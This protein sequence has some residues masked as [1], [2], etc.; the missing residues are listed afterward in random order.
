MSQPM[1]YSMP[2]R[3]TEQ[4]LNFDLSTLYLTEGIIA[5]FLDLNVLARISDVMSG[6]LKF[7]DSPLFP[8]T[9][10]LNQADRSKITIVPGFALGES[11][12]Q[13]KN[14]NYENYES[15]VS[16]VLPGFLDAP[17]CIRPTGKV[18]NNSRDNLLMLP[19]VLSLIIAS[20]FRVDK[21]KSME[22]R[23]CE[24]LKL[25]AELSPVVSLLDIEI[26][27]FIIFESSIGDGLSK[28]ELTACSLIKENFAIS[29]KSK[30]NGIEMLWNSAN[31][32]NYIRA[33][34]FMSMEKESV[35]PL[36][37]WIV[38]SDQK[39]HALLE[40]VKFPLMPIHTLNGSI[41]TDTRPREY[42]ENIYWREVDA[43]TRNLMKSREGMTLYKN[44]AIEFE[45]IFD[46]LRREIINQAKEMWGEQADPFSFGMTG[47]D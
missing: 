31:D 30:K 3:S 38:T 28:R 35:L 32:I 1:Y 2:V 10:I 39:L 5:L 18:H 12:F 34:V 26:A 19:S 37:P 24:Y 27:K 6:K 17:D 9:Q 25:Y 36:V 44:S 43:A 13:K 16:M 22:N 23:F 14:E 15:F 11:N 29:T 46:R 45:R 21:S 33:S 40:R 41:I 4:S 8:L 47:S 42:D 7:H 20:K